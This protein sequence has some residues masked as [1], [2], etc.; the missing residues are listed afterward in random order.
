MVIIVLV[1]F[2]LIIIMHMR[3]RHRLGIPNAIDERVIPNKSI[4]T[5]YAVRERVQL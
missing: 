2:A 5:K 1:T 3:S 4:N